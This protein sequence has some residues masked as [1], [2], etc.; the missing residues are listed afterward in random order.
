M[1]IENPEMREEAMGGP[2]RGGVP[3]PRRRPLP[4]GEAPHPGRHP[5]V[6]CGQDD[7]LKPEFISALRRTCLGASALA[8]LTVGSA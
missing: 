4:R 1:F 2:G 7:D 8:K 6:I 3:C 5:R